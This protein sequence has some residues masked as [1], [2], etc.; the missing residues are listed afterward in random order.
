[1]AHIPQ[2]AFHRDER[3]GGQMNRTYASYRLSALLITAAALFTTSAA[4]HAKDATVEKRLEQ[5][6]MKY[7]IDKDG[8]Y[9]VT[10]DFAREKRTQMIFV[11]GATET[12]NGVVIRKIFSPAGIVARDKID[13]SKA[14]D[15]MR[16]SRIN[17]LGSW[18][19][20]GANLYLVAKLP[21]TLTSAQLHA[22]MMIIASLADDK[23]LELSGA[24]DEL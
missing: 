17:K 10:I 3:E 4:V 20:E 15:L 22:V 13:G 1:M 16:N 23:E 24:R 18:E 6:G 11:S 21:D 7:E 19:I 8:D 2:R 14:L 9:K 5:I 12:A